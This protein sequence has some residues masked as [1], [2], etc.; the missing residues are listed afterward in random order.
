[1]AVSEVS[2]RD[3]DLLIR[4]LSSGSVAR[5]TLRGTILLDP[6]FSPR[7]RELY[8]IGMGASHGIHRV[9]AGGAALPQL[10]DSIGFVGVWH[11]AIDGTGDTLFYARMDAGTA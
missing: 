11:T 1:A 8:F 4:D 7:G 2:D 9:D 5:V 6:V 10:I 3:Q